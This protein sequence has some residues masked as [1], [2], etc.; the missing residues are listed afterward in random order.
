[1]AKLGFFIQSSNQE[2]F[3]N[4]TEVLKEYYRQIIK[5]N[6]LDI[7]LFSFTSD[8]NA[9]NVYEVGDTI[10]CNCNDGDVFSK[11]YLLFKYIKESKKYDW[12]LFTNNTTLVNIFFLYYDIDEFNHDIFYCLNNVHNNIFGEYPN[13]NFK[14]MNF[15]VFL[16]ILDVYETA[17]ICLTPLHEFIYGN[18][19]F[20]K[21][22]YKWYGVP[23]DVIIGRC[24]NKI[25]TS[26]MTFASYN[27]VSLFEYFD[28]RI[29]DINQC[30]DEWYHLF[31]I[32]FRTSW[33]IECN[34]ADNYNYRLQNETNLL[35]QL[36]NKIQEK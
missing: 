8:E 18:E 11:H 6:N 19:L 35:K 32:T 25:Q 10:Y 9:S 23:E 3:K 33:Y 4:N 27:Y 24:L 15:D 31:A 21:C 17:K 20:S 1:M 2:L 14:L 5:D 13:G 26:Y 7:E 34:E 28:S 29:V 12:I 16:K 36:I 30:A 22:P